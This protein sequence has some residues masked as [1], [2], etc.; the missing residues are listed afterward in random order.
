[1]FIP[2]VTNDG[3]Y[4]IIYTSKNTDDIALISVANLFDG[5]NKKEIKE[6]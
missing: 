6:L 5:I 3:K 2:Q 4:I 1:M